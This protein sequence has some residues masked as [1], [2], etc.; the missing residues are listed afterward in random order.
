MVRGRFMRRRWGVVV[1]AVA[2]SMGQG[3]AWAAELRGWP[4]R[5][6]GG[7]STSSPAVGDINGDGTLEV[8]VAAGLALHVLGTHGAEMEGWPLPLKE[9]RKKQ[10]DVPSRSD[11]PAPVTLCDLDGDRAEEIVLL[12]L[13]NRL[14]VLDSRARERAG[15][16]VEGGGL[17]A[18]APACADLDGDGKP[19]LVWAGQDG[20]LRA[21][22]GQARGFPGFPVPGLRLA[23]GLVAVGNFDGL[24]GV[25]LGVGTV[26]GQV[27]VLTRGKGGAW[28]DVPGFPVKTQFTVSGGPVMADLDMD[29]RV[30]LMFGSQ[31]FRIF[32]VRQDGSLLPGF[33]KQTEYRVYAQPAVGDLDGDGNNDM[34]VGGGDGSIYALRADGNAVRGWPVG[35]NGRIIASAAIGDLDADGGLEV[36][37]AG[38][39]GR[40]HVMRGNG[41]PLGGFPMLPGGGLQSAP[42]IVD[43]D[44]DGRMEIILGTATGFV[45]AYSFQNLAQ[46]KKP[47][48]S[49]PTAGHDSGRVS[50]TRPN[51]A[52]FLD[53]S[54][55][56]AGA[57][58]DDDL[59]VAYRH[60]DLDG[61]A[62]KDTQIRWY[63]NGAAVAE[64]NNKAV[65]PAALTR[66]AEK[67]H[68]TL[69]EGADFAAQGEGKGA[70][71]TRSPVLV[72]RN[73]A[74]TTPTV[75]VLPPTPDTLA[76][77]E[78]RIDTPSTDADGDAVVYAYRWVRNRE[79]L[80]DLPLTTTRVPAARTRKGE[81]WRLLVVPTDAQDE[82]ETASAQTTILNTA[83]SA[84]ELALDPET[85]GASTPQKT[86]I[87]VPSADPD[88]DTVVYRY[89]WLLDT[90]PVPFVVDRTDFPALS[91]R[92]GQTISLTVTPWDGEA[93]GP[94]QKRTVTLQNTPPLQPTPLVWPLKART[95]DALWA[96]V[97][98]PAQDWDGD[99]V[100][101]T[102]RWQR[103]GQPLEL[104]AGTTTITPELT[105]KG[106]RFALEATPQD[107][108][109]VGAVGRLELVVADTPP[110]LA[111]VA[112][113]PANPRANQPLKVLVQTDAT[114][115]DG[116]RVSYKVRWVR[117]GQ[118]ATSAARDR[119][120]PAGVLRKKQV[121]QALVTAF[122]GELDGTPAGAVEV[123]VA[124]TPPTV[125][126]VALEPAQPR[127]LDVIRVRVTKPAT[128]VDGDAVTYRQRWFLD[129]MLQDLPPT[130]TEVP[131]DRTFRGQVWR[132]EV[133]PV[134][135][136]TEGPPAFAEATVG[137]TAPGAPV[138]AVEPARPVAGDMLRAV[139]KT[140]AVD[141]DD[142]PVRLTFRWLRNGQDAGVAG[143]VVPAGRVRKADRWTV[144]ALTQDGRDDGA[145][146]R[147]EVTVG[148]T[149]P[150]GPVLAVG[151]PVLRI[152]DVLEPRVQ[153]AAVD[154]DGDPVKLLWVWAVDGKEVVALAGR[155]KLQ[156]GD[157][158]KNQRVTLTVTPQDGTAAGRPVV[159]RWTVE[160]TPPTAPSVRFAKASVAAPEPLAVEL[161]T[162]ATDVDGDKLT[163]RHRLYRNGELQKLTDGK[164][165]PA[166][167]RRGDR[168]TVETAAFDGQVEGP[169][170]RAQAVVVNA[171]PTAPVVAFARPKPTVLGPLEV[172]VQ[173]P[174]TDADGDRL[175]QE[176]R[177]T[178][179]GK[180]V[181]TLPTGT[182]KVPNRL[183]KKGDRWHVD[184][185]SYDGALRSPVASAD[186]VVVN[187]PPT[188][189]K[190]A[191]TMKEG[192]P[193]VQLDVAVT[194]PAVDVDGDPLTYR[195]RFFQNG[196]LLKADESVPTLPGARVL[197][198][199]RVKVEVTVSDGEA[200]A[201]LA[202][203]EVR[204]VT[205][206]PPPKPK[207]DAQGKLVEP[208]PPPPPPTPPELPAVPPSP[209]RAVDDA[210]APGVEPEVPAQ[211]T[212]AVARCTV[213]AATML[214]DGRASPRAAEPLRADVKW[215]PAPPP[216]PVTVRW[217]RGG[218]VVPQVPGN[219]VPASVVRKGEV[220][221]AEVLEG[222]ER[223]G[224]CVEVTVGDTVPTAPA[225]ALEP[226]APR[227][228]QELRVVLAQAASDVDGDKVS[229]RYR[230]LLNGHPQ[231]LADATDRVP[232]AQ[233][234]RGDAWTVV[235]T[236]VADGAAGAPAQAEVRVQN[237]APV[238][239]AL[240]VEPANATA[241]QPLWATVVTPAQ[242]LDGDAVSLAYA[243]TRNGQAVAD[244]AGPMVPAGTS[245]KGDQWVV[246]VV[247]NDGTA[248]GAASTAQQLV[249][250]L[251]PVPPVVGVG[252]VLIRAGASVAATVVRPA[253]DV[254]AD[255]V[256]LD[257]RWLVDGKEQSAWA[258]RQALAPSDLRKNQRVRLE[259]TPRDGVVAGRPAVAE[260]FTAN[261]LP[262]APVVAFEASQ[263]PVTVPLRVTVTTP[264]TDADADA[265]VYR[266]RFFRNGVRVKRPAEDP[267]VGT[268]LLR[269]GD[270]WTV[271]VVAFDGQAEGPPASA[272]A[273]VLNTVPLAPSV[274]VVPA[275]PRT[276]DALTCQVDAPGA[277]PDKDTPTYAI[278]WLRNGVE[279]PLMPQ[280]PLPA[281]AT[282]KGETWACR[283]AQHDGQA[284]GPWA[285][286]TPVTVQ[287]SAPPLPQ[288]TVAPATPR[289]GDTLRCRVR[290][291]STDADAD[292]VAYT[293]HWERNGKPVAALDAAWEVPGAQVRRGDV[294]GCWAEASDGVLSS[295]SAAPRVT[296]T[297]GNTPPVPPVVEIRPAAPRAGEDLRC[298]V[299]QMARDPDD[300]R[301]SY[302]AEWRRNGQVQGFAPTQ[303]V[304]EGRFTAPGQE[305]RC[306]LTATDGREDSEPG[307]SPPVLVGEPRPAAAPA[308]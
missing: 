45:H 239:P 70:R 253:S 290:L 202:T 299:T 276:T 218:Q 34:V 80:L 27:H 209:P 56:P 206:P 113:E 116:D 73:T 263:V 32:G 147:A 58:T 140:P 261:T 117:D 170:A 92:K 200:S 195:Y 216:G 57:R 150:V 268:D 15:F 305:W 159:A 244:V 96:A 165:P 29:G 44:Q 250:N 90:A 272:R 118:D 199:S 219:E 307:R 125:P 50:R 136:G 189:P 242:D 127:T 302:R 177:Y 102:F 100:T 25:E 222:S 197:P 187:T 186:A 274:R 180:P 51:P 84:L 153:T 196:N 163:Y 232:G 130:A 269:K 192:Y 69:Q 185:V 60:V 71:I 63:R 260:L 223:R 275:Q 203:A 226:S 281:T 288:V 81:L 72:I 3:S 289:V 178:L 179:N 148:N 67:W 231:P 4:V 254:D 59:R 28:G 201:P 79:P 304:V 298:E 78:A 19:E 182:R 283:A 173:K 157:F 151:Q 26:D 211:P 306:V 106:Q 174:A 262:T 33:P 193:G 267:V 76:D 155:Q 5:L 98:V 213:V 52:L 238:A 169:V 86:S 77:L 208:P 166:L 47:L 143:P 227:T 297:V 31:D 68:Y 88:N 141:P 161:V 212:P 134:A 101:Y 194:A 121:W 89:T 46:V 110:G 264:A 9:A 39:D 230:W 243:W 256:T 295:G 14:H 135:D 228:G 257:W 221:R 190:V 287:N 6:E 144:E 53:V 198:G 265:L 204:V 142:D 249:G 82:G 240:R 18:A 215:D 48:V 184:V 12:S 234:R 220:W 111:T 296:V 225:V 1:A 282:H 132:V 167:I 266:H 301:V 22:D 17:W 8:V 105:Q 149:P 124:D 158:A 280:G 61:D 133:T 64:L 291:E 120:V 23:E 217:L 74:P 65:V 251:P 183:L 94:S 20:A 241:G 247:P 210:E 175:G 123:T 129:G 152:T 36:V 126:D 108:T 258:G 286:S 95:D 207:K 37:V 49:W 38:G 41:Q 292:P 271:E 145:P 115:A 308:L 97:G 248:P 245:K 160:N 273:V 278:K 293:F 10:D 131:A 138:L 255:P 235:V 191:F 279:T 40:L 103:D 114:D 236:A 35:G 181:T 146:G 107:G 139:V 285:D 62:E 99:G 259:V 154:V 87:R 119:D 16:P 66:K 224:S 42:M 277:D 229:Y 252:P 109:V 112:L 270:V 30:E 91:A 75:S 85:L 300:D 11:F 233:V 7:I 237:T 93:E 205:P 168:W 137:N 83:P 156:K 164:V 122:D 171:A 43:L 176:Y 24:P 2:A 128:D 21:V 214:A 246:T 54:V 294:W 55:Q 303:L 162:P 104:P 284:L 13:D 188:A 172:T